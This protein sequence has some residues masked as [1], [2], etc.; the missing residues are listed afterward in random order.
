[1]GS[2]KK[3]VTFL[4]V[5]LSLLF[6]VSYFFTIKNN[7]FTNELKSTDV[8]SRIGLWT[9]DRTTKE[10]TYAEVNDTEIQQ[11]FSWLRAIQKK[12]VIEVQPSDFEKNIS[13]HIQAE[14]IIA[15][16]SNNEIR[17]LHHAQNTYVMYFKSKKK[18]IYKTTSP[19]FDRFFKSKLKNK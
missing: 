9:Y 3:L 13:D 2:K 11:I 8:V 7:F 15:L 14:V 4:V 18:W 19:E 6:F 1:M 10:N 12:N 17:I 5:T 16:K